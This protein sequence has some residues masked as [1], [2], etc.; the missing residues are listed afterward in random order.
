MNEHRN[1]YLIFVN[2]LPGRF[3]LLWPSSQAE[4]HTNTTPVEVVTDPVRHIR[5]GVPV[6]RRLQ[7]LQSIYTNFRHLKCH[8]LSLL[9]LLLMEGMPI[10][11]TL[12][13]SVHNYAKCKAPGEDDNGL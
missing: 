10:L 6:L 4:E 7:V 13:K 5:T 11:H 12:Y 2:K 8:T 1:V 3:I 9:F